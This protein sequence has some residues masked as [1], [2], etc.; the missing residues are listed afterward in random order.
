M[1]DLSHVEPPLD[2]WNNNY[3]SPGG[4]GSVGCSLVQTRLRQCN[5]ADFKFKIRPGDV[6]KGSN[7]TD[8]NFDAMYTIGSGAR[9][10]D[11]NWGGRRHF[12]HKYGTEYHD[13]RTVDRLVQ[14]MMGTLPQ[15]TWQNKV[16]TAYA[17]KGTKNFL[18][19]PGPFMPAPNA[20]SRGPMPTLYSI[21]AEAYATV[22]GV[23]DQNGQIV[24]SGSVP[25]GTAF[26]PSI[27][28]GLGNAAGITSTGK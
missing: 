12:R 11:T 28:V 22:G 7:I 18:P 10:Y 15:Y 14:P 23:K 9:V 3:I 24:S 8:G 20:L 2:R 16:A 25:V 26:A 5:T 6:P 21:G 17:V 27:Q 1:E 19:V 4:V 13:F